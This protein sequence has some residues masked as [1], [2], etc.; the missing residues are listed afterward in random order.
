MNS[1]QKRQMFYNLIVRIEIRKSFWLKKKQQQQKQ[2]K[3]ALNE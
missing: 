2:E 1:A 3:L